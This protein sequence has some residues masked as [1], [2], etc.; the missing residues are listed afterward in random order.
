M[1][2]QE[3]QAAAAAAL[4]ELVKSTMGAILLGLVFSS[5]V[6]GVTLLQTYQYYDRYWSDTLW[7]KLFVALIG[8]LDTA[9]LVTVIHSNWWFLIQNYGNINSLTIVPW[10]LGVEVGI[11]T[12]IGLLVQSF[13]AMRV[14]MLS[15][16]NRIITGTIILLT[17]TQFVL[18]VYY[19]AKG[20]ETKLAVTIAT[21]TWAST[22]SL[23]C[24]IAGD[25]VITSSMCFFLH[26]SRSGVK[27]TDKLIDVL[28]IYT[29]NT[30]LLTTIC[31]ICTIILSETNSGSYWD[32][33]FYF[34]ISKSYVNS[35]LATLNARERLRKT[36]WNSSATP[37]PLT[38]LSPNR[39][40]AG[41]DEYSSG[42]VMQ[43]AANPS[44]GQFDTLAGNTTTADGGTFM[45]A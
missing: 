12:S 4:A 17:T 13:F 21:I 24:S 41:L 9:Q 32:T 20:Q 38:G 15:R 45:E 26:R 29:V 8:A 23:A 14:W 36:V 11:T 40:K 27:R 43:F 25:V 34:M 3:T 44:K 35:A 16:G 30:G 18:G 6:F 37:V 42:S 22:A 10:S 33:M 1:S 28:I 19:A 7:L 2:D 31:A 5:T 39:P